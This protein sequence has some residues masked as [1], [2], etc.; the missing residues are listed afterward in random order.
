MNS[1]KTNCLR[2]RTLGYYHDSMGSMLRR[3]LGPSG[4]FRE[5][6]TNGV[7]VS[8]SAVKKYLGKWSK[9]P[10]SE[11]LAIEHLQEIPGDREYIQFSFIGRPGQQFAHPDVEGRKK[12]PN[13]HNTHDKPNRPSRPSGTDEVRMDIVQLGPVEPVSSVIP[14][15]PKRDGKKPAKPVPVPKPAVKTNVFPVSP[16]TLTPVEPLTPEPPSS[17]VSDPKEW[18]SDLRSNAGSNIFSRKGDAWISS[19]AQVDTSS[20]GFFAHAGAHLYAR[21]SLPDMVAPDLRRAALD[22]NGQM[23]LSLTQK[24]W[25]GKIIYG[26]SPNFSRRTRGM[27]EWR[28]FL[29]SPRWWRR[30]L[31]V[32]GSLGGYFLPFSMAWAG[33]G[34]EEETNLFKSMCPEGRPSGEDGKEYVLPGEMKSPETERFVPQEYLDFITDRD[35]LTRGI[36]FRE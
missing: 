28:E 4:I 20:A 32:D 19:G 1:G 15:R 34:R 16:T 30:K 36:Y 12:K 10:S 29:C 2:L 33:M 23:F 21:T 8:L 11:V 35:E 6:R 3:G 14:A 7:P 27:N 26:F 17:P 13:T 22:L 9:F 18:W 25:N 5:L 24:P 31:M